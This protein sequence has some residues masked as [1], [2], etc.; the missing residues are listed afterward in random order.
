MENFLSLM[1]S[2]IDPWMSN[3]SMDIAMDMT[4]GFMCG[5]GLFFLLIPFLKEYPVSPASENEWDKPQDVKRWQRKTSKKTATGKGCTDS[6]K[7]CRRD[8]DT[9]TTYGNPQ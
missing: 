5:V 6:G 4:I 1:N 8:E 7:K 9:I 2:I 3:S